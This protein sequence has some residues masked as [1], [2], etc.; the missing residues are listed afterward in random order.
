MEAPGS[1]FLADMVSGY[2]LRNTGQY[3]QVTAEP[4]TR[5]PQLIHNAVHKAGNHPEFVASL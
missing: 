4:S 1:A 3:A 5:H 2:T